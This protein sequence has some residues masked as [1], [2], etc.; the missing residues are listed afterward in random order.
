MRQTWAHLFSITIG[1]KKENTNEN[2]IFIY[3]SAE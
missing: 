3:R 1:K 2:T